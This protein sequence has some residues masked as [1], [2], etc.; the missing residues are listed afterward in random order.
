[1]VAVRDWAADRI[2]TINALRDITLRDT[3]CADDRLATILTMLGDPTT[4]AML[5]AA[6][7]Q[8][9]VRVYRLPTETV[10][11][12]S[13]SVSLY[14]DDVADDSLLQHGW[15]KDHRP[16]LRQFKLMRPRSTPWAC[17]SA[18]SRSPGT[19]AII[20]STSRPMTRRLRRWA[21][22]MS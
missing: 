6:L 7:M 1:M 4:Q 13:T 20:R 5:D 22:A 8:R 9:W 12:D 15:S 11:L 18:A 2:Q 14:H 16:D 3:D 17:R 19:A 21:P 10:R